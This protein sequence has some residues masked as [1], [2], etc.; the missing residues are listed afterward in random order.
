MVAWP[1]LHSLPPPLPP[2]AGWAAQVLHIGDSERRDVI[3]AKAF[4]FD[5]LLWGRDITD[6]N[7]LP[8]LV[9]PGME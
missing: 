9:F 7:Q 4:G 2:F 8:G 1:H 6:F 3:G 5:A